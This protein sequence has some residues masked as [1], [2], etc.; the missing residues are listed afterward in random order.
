MYNR[1]QQFI[2]DCSEPPPNILIRQRIRSW[3]DVTVPPPTTPKAIGSLLLP[4]EDVFLG[5]RMPVPTQMRIRSLNRL[6]AEEQ[7]YIDNKH[8]DYELFRQEHG[9]AARYCEIC[10]EVISYVHDEMTMIT[11]NHYSSLKSRLNR[12]TDRWG[13]VSCNSCK[14][15]K[16]S[17]YTGIRYPVLMTSSILNG[18]Q[19][20]MMAGRD[21]G[22]RFH[23]ENV[24][25][26]GAK[27]QDLHH[28]F[29][30][31]YS[32]SEIPVDLLLVAGFNNLLE[33]QTPEMI[34]D[35]MQHFKTDVLN[36]PM[37]SFAVSTLPLAPIISWLPKDNYVNEHRD[38]TEDMIT[39]NH[40]IRELNAEPGQPTYTKWAPLYHTWGLRSIRAPRELGPRRLLEALPAHQLNDWREQRPR[41]QLHLN[42]KVR[43]RMGRAVENYFGHIYKIDK[44]NL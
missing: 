20:D 14:E 9:E 25:I 36:I 6:R 40:A 22:N 43:S 24:G 27:V 15:E 2:P 34:I 10:S 37:S 28:A 31:E 19:G 8:Q 38:H 1:Q 23:I 16:H 26:P 7:R 4:W 21:R 33:G 5:S 13:Q 41:N 17:V 3:H 35:E 18:W 44:S 30:A 32:N 42:Q 11:H 12:T 39:L 29:I